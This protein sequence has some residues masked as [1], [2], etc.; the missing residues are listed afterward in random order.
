MQNDGNSIKIVKQ[1]TDIG[2]SH[3]I[4]TTNQVSTCNCTS[5]TK[6]KWPQ[7]SLQQTTSH[8]CVINKKKKNFVGGNNKL[9]LT[10]VHRT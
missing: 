4:M 1:R 5:H 8:C 9:T 2:N 7:L 10:M 6:Q 3:R